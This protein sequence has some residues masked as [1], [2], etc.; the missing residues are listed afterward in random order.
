MALATSAEIHSAWVTHR[1]RQQCS[2][3]VGGSDACTLSLPFVS[4]SGMR[5]GIFWKAATVKLRRR[6]IT[7]FHRS[8]AMFGKKRLEKKSK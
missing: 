4:P 7:N 8:D 3:R 5:L 2:W 6:A 1:A